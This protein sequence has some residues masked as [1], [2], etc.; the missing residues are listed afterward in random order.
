M[1]NTD[2]RSVATD[3]LETLGKIIDKNAGRDAIHL[4]VEPVMAAQKLHAGDHVG[5]LPSGGVGTG[6]KKHLGIVDPFL[7][8]PVQKGQ[9]FWLVV[10]PRQ[11]TSL[12]H[13]WTHPDFSEEG[14][15]D[16]ETWLRNFCDTSD[17]PSYETLMKALRNELIDDDDY[18]DCS[19]RWDGDYLYF[20][21]LDAHASI[22]PEFWDHVSNVLGYEVDKTMR[23]EY[24]SCSC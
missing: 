3:A 24:F 8:S 1:T 10:Y 7:K 22:P 20:Q 13:V 14:K 16:S 18:G 19:F 6:A 9:I 21:G 11:I 4:A 5:F 17:C 15:V 2:K 12:R 23:P